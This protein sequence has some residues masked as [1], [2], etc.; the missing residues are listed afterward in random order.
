MCLT[1]KGYQR[2]MK[3]AVP[4]GLFLAAAA[5][6]GQGI[7]GSLRGI[8]Q[9][10]R[11]ARI[12]SAT[13]SVR[14]TGNAIS[15]SILSD[16]GGHFRMD[17]LAPGDYSVAVTAQGFEAAVAGVSVKVSSIQDITVT[18]RPL[19]EQQTVR[20]QAQS[21]SISTQVIDGA[22]QVHQAVISA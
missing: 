6:L 18:L 21:S 13:I 4:L 9:D 8:V 1:W 22:S 12:V 15:R 3:L 17:D 10:S 14:A 19:L 2:V 16:E 5:C 11:Q 7:G 20:V